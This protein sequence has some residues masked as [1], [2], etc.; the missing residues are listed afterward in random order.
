MKVRELEKSNQEKFSVWRLKYQIIKQK[1]TIK[2]LKLEKGLSQFKV[3]K[4]KKKNRKI[5]IFLVIH[6]G[7]SDQKDRFVSSTPKKDKQNKAK[8]SFV[9]EGTFTG[10]QNKSQGK[11]DSTAI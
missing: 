7:V 10:T 2:C 4:K 3:T 9:N 8:R 6:E 5:I 11:K 1:K